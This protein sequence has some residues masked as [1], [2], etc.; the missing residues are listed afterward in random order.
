MPGTNSIHP[1]SAPMFNK[2]RSFRNVLFGAGFL[3]GSAVYGQTSVNIEGNVKNSPHGVFPLTEVVAQDAGSGEVYQSVF[4]DVSGDYSLEFII[5]GLGESFMNSNVV[6]PN[7]FGRETVIVYNAV[8]SGVRDFSVSN[9]LGQE[10]FSSSFVVDQG[11]VASINV[12]GLGEPGLYFAVISG[13]SGKDVFKLVQTE[14]DASRVVDFSV[15]SGFSLKQGFSNDIKLS[16]LSDTHYVKDTLLSQQ[17]HFGVDVTLLQVPEQVNSLYSIN[18]LNDVMQQPVVGSV[19]VRDFDSGELLFSG[20]SNVSG[21]FS[22][23]FPVNKWSWPGLDPIY[24]VSALETSV[25]AAHHDFL[26]RVDDYAEVMSLSSVLSQV[27]YNSNASLSVNLTSLPLGYG[28]SGVFLDVLHNGSSVVS[29][30]TSNGSASFNFGYDFVQNGSQVMN[31]INGVHVTSLDVSASHALHEPRVFS[32]AFSSSMVV[33]ET[34]NQIPEQ[35]TTEI[36]TNVTSVPFNYGPTGAVVLAQNPGNG[37]TLYQGSTV[38]GVHV[39]SFDFLFWEYGDLYQSTVDDVALNV[40][41]TNHNPFNSVVPNVD[42]TVNAV[43]EQL[44][45]QWT[46]TINTYVENNMFNHPLQGAS[47]VYVNP[48]TGGAL[49][50]GTTNASGNFNGSFSHEVWVNA[51]NPEQ[52]IYAIPQVRIDASATQHASGTQTVANQ[53]QNVNMVL[54]QQPTQMTTTITTTVQND[55]FGYMMPGANVSYLNPSNGSVL[56]QGTTNASG[57]FNN[58]F[59]HNVWIH[60]ADP[61][62]V[63]YAVPEVQVNVSATQHASGTQTVTNE[64]QTLE[65]ILQQI[66]QNLNAN[67]SGQVTNPNN[68][69]INQ[70]LVTA[71]DPDNAMMN[72]TNTNTQ[73]NYSFTLNYEAW[74]NPVNPEQSFTV[75]SHF[76]LNFEKTGYTMHTTEPKN[77]APNIVHNQTLTPEAQTYTFSI[78][79][80]TATNKQ[81]S[82]VTTQPFTFHVRTTSDNQVHSFTQSGNNPVQFTITGSYNPEEIVKFWHNNPEGKFDQTLVLEHPNQDWTAPNIAQTNIVRNWFP[83]MPMDTLTTT[84][85]NLSNPSYANLIEAYF[86]EQ[87]LLSTTPNIYLPFSG[88]TIMTMFA[89]RTG[90]NTVKNWKYEP[91]PHVD[92]V[93]FLFRRIAGD[94]WNNSDPITPAQLQVINTVAQGIDQHLVSASG[95][96]R[97]PVIYNYV[98][99]QADAQEFTDR[100]WDYT[101]RSWYEIGQP[102]NGVFLD[103]QNYRIKASSANF[104]PNSVQG[105]IY[106]EHH[107]ALFAFGN[108]PNNMPSKYYTSFNALP[109]DIGKTMIYMASMLDPFTPVLVWNQKSASFEPDTTDLRKK[110]NDS[111][112]NISNDYFIESEDLESKCYIWSVED[113]NDLIYEYKE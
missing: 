11:G 85:G 66:P 87:N 12:R 82:E 86:P 4:T 3:L 111:T 108:G 103:P 92:R 98:N 95:R 21:N 91:V 1:F 42:Q 36:T 9:V 55:V 47:V 13:G 96:V 52:V 59:T 30:S 67:V 112:K 94:P 28:P 50:Q 78:H 74:N 80:Y 57:V 26:Q 100:G 41:S 89:D 6:R 24:S 14:S 38:D 71:L 16:F 7:P 101:T 2:H 113:N 40:S 90:Y 19:S 84:L 37:S 45:E 23:S 29:G 102:L 10:V 110:Y 32:K 49:T 53:N 88:D 34:L 79:P 31:F 97:M 81:V 93:I 75:P 69:P 68:Q 58:P 61:G 8:S 18:L 27:W 39:G 46:T 20:S 54:V 33:N 70:V 106:E 51:T 17:N 35:G 60:P 5:T 25:S 99:S 44:P 62:Q 77:F 48:S 65:L 56:T 104:P 83:G 107:E 73:G 63:I 72:N 109:N 22:R 15:S 76:L 64:D 43:L 105:D